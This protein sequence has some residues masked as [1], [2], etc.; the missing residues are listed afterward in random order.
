MEME[1]P[2]LF[3][4]PVHLLELKVML[5]L[6]QPFWNVRSSEEPKPLMVEQKPRR[7]VYN[8]KKVLGLEEHK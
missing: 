6:Q 3:L 2:S 8:K 5:E 7:L 1:C 4:L